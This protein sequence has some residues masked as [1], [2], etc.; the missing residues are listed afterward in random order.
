[1]RVRTQQ[2]ASGKYDVISV[3]TLT[4][5]TLVEPFHSLN[6]N[7]LRGRTKQ[8]QYPRFRSSGGR[9]WFFYDGSW[10]LTGRE[11]R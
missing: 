11:D 2:V 4:L 8:V 5:E 3:P 1:M 7:E 6:D 10:S 9:H